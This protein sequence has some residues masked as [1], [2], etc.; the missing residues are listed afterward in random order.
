MTIKIQQMLYDELKGKIFRYPV[1]TCPDDSIKIPY[2]LIESISTSTLLY[3]QESHK[4]QEVDVTINIYDKPYSNKNCL[5]GLDKAK[6]ILENLSEKFPNI[7]NLSITT[8]TQHN[9]NCFLG[10]LK[11]N[12][13]CVD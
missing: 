6:S 1:H 4:Y 9:K 12:F 3:S 2:I 11:L 10:S 13:Y 7:S 8:E 5:D